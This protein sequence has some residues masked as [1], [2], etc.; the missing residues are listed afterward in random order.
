[1]TDGNACSVH[2]GYCGRCSNEPRELFATCADCG[3]DFSKAE[4]DPTVWCDACSDRR[5]AWASAL[6]LRMAHAPLP[7][8]EARCCCGVRVARHFHR[9]RRLTCAQAVRRWGRD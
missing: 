6:E 4:D 2:C 9:A 1:M 5:D 7:V 3:A 8:D